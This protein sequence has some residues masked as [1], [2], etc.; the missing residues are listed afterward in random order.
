M[1]RLFGKPKPFYHYILGKHKGKWIIMGLYQNSQ[2]RNKAGNDAFGKP[3][4]IEINST[5]KDLHGVQHQLKKRY[6]KLESLSEL[7]G[8]YPRFHITIEAESKIEV[9]RNGKT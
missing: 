7:L 8:H 4:F 1:C 6:G 9:K 2:D 5:L 3:N